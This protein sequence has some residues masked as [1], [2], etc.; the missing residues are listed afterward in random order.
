MLEN[1]GAGVGLLGL[2]GMGGVGKTALAREIYNQCATEKKFRHMTFLEIQR[3]P[4]SS[5]VQIRHSGFGKM[6]GQL[7]WDLL[8]A[9]NTHLNYSA[10]FEKV[11]TVGPVLIVVDYVDIESQLEALIPYTSALH[12]GSRVIVT[13]R[14]HSI[15]KRAAAKLKIKHDVYGV[16]PLGSDEA[17][18]LFNWHAFQAKEAVQG[19]QELAMEVVA[20]CGGLPLALKVIGSSLFDQT[21]DVD[22]ETIWPEAVDALRKNGDVM[23]VLRWS[24][25]NLGES[26]KLMFQDITCTFYGYTVKEALEYWGSRN[27]SSSCG[28]GSTPHTSLRTLMNKNLVEQGGVQMGYFRV[29]DLLRDLGKEVGMESRRHFVDERIEEVA[30]MDNKVRY[31]ICVCKCSEDL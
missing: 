15:V 1:M 23:G 17:N 9:D 24:Y 30:F 18:A 29:H 6:R 10:R 19:F 25:D 14:D 4:S 7:L 26:E 27:G 28:G 13:T 3:D 22:R 2:A 8:R 5:N 31:Y 12:P 20:S 21:S 11:S 16:C